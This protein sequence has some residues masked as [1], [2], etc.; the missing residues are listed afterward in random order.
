M[1]REYEKAKL[2]AI[3]ND[4]MSEDLIGGGQMFGNTASTFDPTKTANSSQ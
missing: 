3:N 4:L 1:L 2:N